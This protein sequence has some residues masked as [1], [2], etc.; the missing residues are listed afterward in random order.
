MR[1][2]YDIRLTAELKREAGAVRDEGRCM[3]Q[4]YSIEFLCPV[5]RVWNPTGGATTATSFHMPR[6]VDVGSRR[7][8]L[9][10]GHMITANC[11][12]ARLGPEINQRDLLPLAA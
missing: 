1:H 12:Q 6:S 11:L 7:L 10:C 9:P 4:W 5:C 8:G 3:S 2:A